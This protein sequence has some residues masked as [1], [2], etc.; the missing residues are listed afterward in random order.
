MLPYISDGQ[1]LVK[2]YSSNHK[3]RFMYSFNGYYNRKN[4]D[5]LFLSNQNI[6]NNKNIVNSTINSTSWLLNYANLQPYNPNDL[7]GKL[8]LGTNFMYTFGGIHILFSQLFLKQTISTN[9][10]D[11]FNLLFGILIEIAGFVSY[12]YHY[13]QLRYGPNNGVVRKAL[14]IDYFVASFTIL[15]V[16]AQACFSI[17]TLGAIPII[18]IFFGFISI[19]FLLLSWKY[20]YGLPYMLFHGLWHIFSGLCVLALPQI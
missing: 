18:S 15:S 1:T 9:T 3:L 8:F 12:N 14:I 6:E 11:I 17:A 13:T 2:A 7:Y 4:I 16:I 5:A 20:E 19:L 10:S